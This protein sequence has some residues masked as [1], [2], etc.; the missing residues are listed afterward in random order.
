MKRFELWKIRRELYR[1]RQQVV[2]G[3]TG[4]LYDQPR[5]YFHD[6]SFG[7]HLQVTVGARSFGN[8]IALFVLYQPAGIAA[9]ICF[10]LDHLA[11]QGWSPLVV[12]NAPLSAPDRAALTARAALVVERPNVGYD[13][14]AYR[15]GLRVMTERGLRPERLI[16]MNDSTWFPLRE[17]D[18]SLA[19]ME[20]SGLDMI[21]HN[22][23]IEIAEE[24]KHDHVESHLLMFSG[25]ALNHPAFAEFWRTYLMSNF[26][27]LTIW[28]GE[29]GLTDAMRHAALSFGGL[30]SRDRMV[31][32]LEVLDPAELAETVGQL[33]HYRPEQRAISDALLARQPHDEAWRQA[34]LKMCHDLLTGRHHFVSTTFIESA[35]RLGGLG[36]VKKDKDLRHNLA[37]I[38]V[39]EAVDAG[40]LAPLQ[41]DVRREMC[42]MVDRWVEPFDWRLPPGKK[43]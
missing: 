7:N 39:L 9:S 42:Q 31:Q 11:S 5:Q 24:P 22:F 3:V 1:M 36:F 19:R 38:R 12:S 6:R 41:D 35:M 28:R 43:E 40:R 34:V 23:K 2:H 17:G 25:K 29:K 21:G 30:L 20:A 8:K 15:D 10:T 27:E 26:R 32:L 13:F 18:T 33:S 16:L 4:A 14:G 37:R